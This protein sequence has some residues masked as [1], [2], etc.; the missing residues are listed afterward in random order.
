MKKIITLLFTTFLCLSM[1]AENV[2]IFGIT[3]GMTKQEIKKLDLDK[4]VETPMEKALDS[5]TR[6]IEVEVYY[7][8]NDKVNLISI[9]SRWGDYADMF[10]AYWMAV[11]L[12]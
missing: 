5:Y 3:F 2:T 9:Y 8:K 4:R 10:Q 1:Y 6:D 12:Q 7:D 11:F